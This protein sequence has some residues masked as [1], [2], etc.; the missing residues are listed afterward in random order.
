MQKRPITRLYNPPVSREGE[1]VAPPG[2]REFSDVAD[3]LKAELERLQVNIHLG[4]EFTVKR[5]QQGQPEVVITIL[6][7]GASRI[8][9]VAWHRR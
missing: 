2:K 7:S 6:A 5:M 4:E 3:F 8:P 1:K 9:G